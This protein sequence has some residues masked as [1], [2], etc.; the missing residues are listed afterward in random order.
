MLWLQ[1][2]DFTD[3]QVNLP[4]LLGSSIFKGVKK[5]NKFS[6]TESKIEGGKYLTDAATEVFKD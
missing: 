1:N 3:F 2:F 6:G 5:M 4:F